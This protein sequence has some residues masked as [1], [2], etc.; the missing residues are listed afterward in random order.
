M[1]AVDVIIVGA[2]P[3]GIAAAIQSRREGLEP[4]VFEKD[5]A[6]G[7]L[8]NANLVENYP[9]FPAGIPGP[10]LIARM[11]RQ[12]KEYEI[13]PVRAEVTRIAFHN[14]L[15]RVET[16]SDGFASRGVIVA[17]GTR[18]KVFTD[19]EI[20]EDARDR[21]FYEVWP[22]R[23][24]TG[25]RVVV[26]GAGDIGF[27]YAL[28][29]ASANDIALLNRGDEASCIPLLRKRARA[30]ER[31]RYVTGTRLAG[32]S[33]SESG[34]LWLTLNGAGG[35]E[36]Q[37]ADYLVFAIGREP[38]RRFLAADAAEEL[39]RRG[40]LLLAGDVK[41]GSLRQTAIAAGDGIGAAMTLARRLRRPA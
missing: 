38:E 23:G 1:T 10:A 26:V 13:E 2:G 31:I 41:N 3:A 5:S 11:R 33:R 29:L 30:H 37:A 6:G 22:L 19:A 18:P 35:V 36:T 9:G 34:A 40:L 24:V 32:V 14:G 16:E 12:L 20:P 25:R 17:S 8:R 39:E 15:C 27:D 4:Q 28:N 21:V 7:L